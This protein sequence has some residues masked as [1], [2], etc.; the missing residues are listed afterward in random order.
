[1]GFLLGSVGV[2]FLL[3]KRVHGRVEVEGVSRW[4]ANPQAAVLVETAWAGD[5]KVDLGTAKTE[6]FFALGVEEVSGAFG[7]V[8][9]GQGFAWNCLATLLSGISRV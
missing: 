1:M 9:F 3:Q 8:V 5:K 4:L 2:E 6:G 7:G